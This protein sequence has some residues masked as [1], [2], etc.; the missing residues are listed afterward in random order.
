MSTAETSP[1][2]A[3]DIDR[4]TNHVARLGGRVARWLVPAL[5]I[6]AAAWVSSSTSSGHSVAAAPAAPAVPAVRTVP[7][8][9]VEGARLHSFSGSVRAESHSVLAFVNGGRLLARRV[10]VGDAVSAGEVLA[11][12]DARPVRH[13]RAATS[14]QIAGLRTQ[15][16]QLAR[17]VDRVRGLSAEG[18]APLQQHEQ[19]EAQLSTMRSSIAA[20]EAQE[21]DQRRQFTDATLRAPFDGVVTEVFA[22]EGEVLAPG[23][24]VLR[25]AATRGHEVELHLPESLIGAVAA[26]DAVEVAFPLAEVP[27]RTGTVS[28][29][30]R[31][32]RQALYPVRV[33]ID[34][35]DGLHAGLTAEITFR[36]RDGGRVLLPADA[37]RAPT[38]NAAWVL[39]V[40]DESRIAMVPIEVEGASEA[41]IVVRAALPEG[42][43]VVVGAPAGLAAGSRVQVVP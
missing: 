15:H 14:A 16:D 12:V 18:A 41:G 8:R 1:S 25:L 21:A 30:S 24:S 35:V 23:Q 31:S 32:T 26:G 5:C 6:L 39:V 7:A 36:I 40:D 2:L 37:I 9:A 10:K 11:R 20:A 29:V 3:P 34:D 42:S 38:S 19:L 22:Q 4:P 27:A 13:A 17:D 28:A 33:H 43:R